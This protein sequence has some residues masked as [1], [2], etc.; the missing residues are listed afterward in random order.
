MMF[1]TNVM[2]KDG[3]LVFDPPVEEINS[4][5]SQFCDLLSVA[6]YRALQSSSVVFDLIKQQ[7]FGDGPIQVE[8]VYYIKVKK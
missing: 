4:A 2:M 6:A 3:Q 5:W 1:V 8:N 7:Q